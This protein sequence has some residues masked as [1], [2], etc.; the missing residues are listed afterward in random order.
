[1]VRL[2]VVTLGVV[3]RKHLPVALDLGDDPPGVSV[4][5]EREPFQAVFHRARLLGERHRVLAQVDED[6][7]ADPI[8]VNRVQRVLRGVEPR[9]RLV[10]EVG[11]HPGVLEALRRALEVAVEAERPEVVRT[12]DPFGVDRIGHRRVVDELRTPVG[13]DVVERP[14]VAVVIAQNDQ[15]TV[16]DGSREELPRRVDTV[17]VPGVHPV[18]PEHVVLFGFEHLAV[19]EIPRRQ[20]VRLGRDVSVYPTRPRLV[21]CRHTVSRTER[22]YQSVDDT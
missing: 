1:M 18:L 5:A 2:A 8:D 12:A 16:P 4:L 19:G 17:R 22:V 13:T 6:E 14:D 10:V 9:D 15:L 3:A 7:R 21:P 11:V 20:R